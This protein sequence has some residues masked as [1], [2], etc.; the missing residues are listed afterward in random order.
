MVHVTSTMPL[1]GMLSLG[2]STCHDQPVCQISTRYEDMKGDRKC[3][4]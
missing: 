3:G 2:Y 4:K 1:S